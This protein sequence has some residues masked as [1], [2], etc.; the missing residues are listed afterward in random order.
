[1]IDD[2]RVGGCAQPSTTGSTTSPPT[3]TL[4]TATKEANLAVART[5]RAMRMVG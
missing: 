3:G 1:M 4:D 5:V 2:P